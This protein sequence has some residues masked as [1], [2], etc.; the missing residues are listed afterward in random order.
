MNYFVV[1]YHKHQQVLK[2]TY[3]GEVNFRVQKDQTIRIT[4]LLQVLYT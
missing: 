3:I 1:S 2:A 4:K